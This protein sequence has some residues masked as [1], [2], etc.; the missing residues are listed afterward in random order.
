MKYQTSDTVTDDAD[1]DSNNTA[2]DDNVCLPVTLVQ[3][4]KAGK[5]LYE[6]VLGEK[7]LEPVTLIED[8]RVQRLL[9]NQEVVC[10]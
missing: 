5:D 1:S 4:E 2:M 8:M 3:Y 7:E 10:H 6:G 9:L